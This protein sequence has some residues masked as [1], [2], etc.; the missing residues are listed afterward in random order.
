MLIHRSVPL[1]LV[2]LLS[3]ASAGCQLIGDIFQAGV[4]VGVLVV[5]VVLGL[6]GWLLSRLF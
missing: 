3:I 6:V 4:V 5:V 2:V 1:L